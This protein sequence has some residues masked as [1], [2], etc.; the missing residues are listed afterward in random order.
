MATNFSTRLRNARALA[1]VNDINAGAGPGSM[2]FCTAPRPAGG[3]AITTQ[4]LLG[5]CPFAEPAGSVVNGVLTMAALTDDASA[6]AT[7][8]ARWA[9]V[10]DG[11]GNWVKDMDIAE[12]DGTLRAA[13]GTAEG[14]D[15]AAPVKMASCHVYQGGAL[16][17][18]SFFITEGN[19]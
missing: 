16:H 13:D 2:L 17:V 7:G 10:L 11:D 18:T 9:R 1:I 15:A 14:T 19:A 3:A 4:T 6:D 8:W 5:T 12:N